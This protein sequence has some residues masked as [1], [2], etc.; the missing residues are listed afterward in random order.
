LRAPI[1]DGA[2]SSRMPASDGV[3]VALLAVAATQQV[4]MFQSS[5]TVG[6]RYDVVERGS[7]WRTAGGKTH[8]RLSR[9]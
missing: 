6:H 9:A 4:T 7:S 5:A 8:M 1:P 3:R 2:R